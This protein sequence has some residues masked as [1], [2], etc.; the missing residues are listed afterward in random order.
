MKQEDKFSC[1][2]NYIKLFPRNLKQKELNSKSHF[3]LLFGP[4]KCKSFNQTQAFLTYN[5]KQ[6]LLKKQIDTTADRFTHLYTFIIKPDQTYQILIDN[7]EKAS[8]HFYDDWDYLEPKMVNYIFI[9]N[10]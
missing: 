6:P 5:Q 9:I 7:E 4:N 3:N 1:S 10:I 8:G 2:S